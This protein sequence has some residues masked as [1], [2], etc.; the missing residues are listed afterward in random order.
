MSPQTKI[1]VSHTMKIVRR[2]VAAFLILGVGYLYISTKYAYETRRTAV[3][4]I[5]ALHTRLSVCRIAYQET[6]EIIGS[7]RQLASTYYY[8]YYYTPRTPNDRARV[9]FVVREIN[10]NIVFDGTSRYKEY[11]LKTEAS[12]GL[13]TDTNRTRLLL[14]TCGSGE[15][16][17]YGNVSYLRSLYQTNDGGIDRTDG[18]SLAGFKSIPPASSWNLPKNPPELTS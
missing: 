15:Q 2:A 12:T 18:E 13:L 8:P 14:A 16:A 10:G 4:G 5:I 6:G 7:Q 9:S 11:N 17:V 3:E 1:N